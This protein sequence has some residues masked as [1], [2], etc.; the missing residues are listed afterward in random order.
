MEKIPQINQV[1]LKLF[2]L[3]SLNDLIDTASQILMKKG[4]GSADINSALGFCAYLVDFAHPG[5][6]FFWLGLAVWV[7]NFFLWMFI[8]SKTDLSIAMPLAS[9]SYILVPCAA[10]VF[11]HEGIPPLRWAGLALIVAGIYYVS[12]S[13]PTSRRQA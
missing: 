13:K 7:S 2:L 5:L 3:I 4:L 9:I 12:Q 1:P 6:V 11:L 10:M 8:L